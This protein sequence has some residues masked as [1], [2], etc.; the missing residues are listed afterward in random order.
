MRGSHGCLVLADITNPESLNEAVEWRKQIIQFT[1][2]GED[3]PTYLIVNKCDLI[4]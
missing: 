1:E 3:L 4:K 2:L